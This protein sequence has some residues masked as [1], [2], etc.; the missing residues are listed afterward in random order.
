MQS[1]YVVNVEVPSSAIEP[2]SS[3]LWE[4]GTTGIE[5]RDVAEGRVLLKAYFAEAPDLLVIQDTLTK[6]LGNE[7][8]I[9]AIDEIQNEDWLAK[10]KASW[11][12]FTVGESFL[13][14]PSWAKDSLCTERV[15][16]ELDPGMAFG[17]GTHETTQ[18]CLEA[19]EKYWRGGRMLDVGTGTGIL[20]IAAALLRPDAVIDACD[21]DPEAIQI[22]IENAKKNSV[23]INFLVG[24]IKD[25]KDQYNLVTANLTADVILDNLEE[26][27]A[28]VSAGGV[29]VVSGILSS[30]VTAISEALAAYQLKVEARQAGEWICLCSYA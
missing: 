12:P 25:Y 23:Q 22:A 19:I 2:A 27:L 5:E 13:I 8:L 30:Q 14:T 26:L 20:A 7:I 18:L 29:L 24:S 9:R 17:T 1:W 3:V 28:R 16:I 4:A 15:L 11:K 21:I 6:L 10:W